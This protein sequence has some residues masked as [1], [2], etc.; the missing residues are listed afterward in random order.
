MQPYCTIDDFPPMSAR[1]YTDFGGNLA[2][3]DVYAAAVCLSACAHSYRYYAGMVTDSLGQSLEGESLLK[4]Q[5]LHPNC[6]SVEEYQVGK[7]APMIDVIYQPKTHGKYFT[8][9]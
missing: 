9:Y 2:V 8:P 3:G 6:S 5:G 1:R 4:L 7:S